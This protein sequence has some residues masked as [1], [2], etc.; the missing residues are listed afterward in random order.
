MLSRQDF[1]KHW[2]AL[3]DRFKTPTGK[4][5]LLIFDAV[6][7][8][9]ERQWAQLVDN[10]IG[11]AKTI[12]TVTEF[13]RMTLTYVTS[14]EVTYPCELCDGAGMQIKRIWK[15]FYDIAIRCTCLNGRKYPMIPNEIPKDY[16]EKV[17][18]L[19]GEKNRNG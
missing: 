1:E 12:P 8:L 4:L 14:N 5:S 11:D 13:K 2:Q 17:K 10:V 16:V 15:N 18:A 9:N 6:K 19:Y 3:Q 7:I